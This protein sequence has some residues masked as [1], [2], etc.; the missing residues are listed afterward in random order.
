MD[1]ELNSDLVE[2]YALV[3]PAEPG[4][5]D[6]ASFARPPRRDVWAYAGNE[7]A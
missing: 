2:A 6:L 1:I 5:A 3:R 4:S 7:E